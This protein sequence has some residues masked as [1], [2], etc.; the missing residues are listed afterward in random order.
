MKRTIRQDEINRL[1]VL[2]NMVRQSRDFHAYNSVV[3]RPRSV[4]EGSSVASSLLKGV[5]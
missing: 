4:N 5:K 2:T 3:I 1:R